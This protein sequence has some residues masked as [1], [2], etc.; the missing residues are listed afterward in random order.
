M[1]TYSFGNVILVPFP[2][3]DQS[4]S[5]KRPAVIISSDTYQCERLDLILIA[6]TSQFNPIT[7]FGEMVITEWQAAGLLKPSI[8]KPVL[9]TIDRQ[10][11]LKKLGKLQEPDLQSLQT[12]LQS[13]LG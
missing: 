9:T 13:I 2:F 6:I 10:L 4:I 11:V 12:L 5:K 8:I 7:N 1:T 3:T